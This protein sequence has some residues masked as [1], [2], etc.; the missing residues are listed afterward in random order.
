M[1][2]DDVEALKIAV[3]GIFQKLP[4]Q[5]QNEIVNQ[6][7]FSP[8]KHELEAPDERLAVEILRGF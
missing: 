2:G 5:Q 1:K 7:M 6:I 3:H 4:E 8:L